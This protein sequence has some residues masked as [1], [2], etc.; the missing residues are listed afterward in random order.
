MLF[1]SIIFIEEK[2]KLFQCLRRGYPSRGEV[3]ERIRLHFRPTRFR[4]TF[5][6][7]EYVSFYL[8]LFLVE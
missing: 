1:V 7:L 2:Q 8:L 3:H 6:V 4:W 5:P